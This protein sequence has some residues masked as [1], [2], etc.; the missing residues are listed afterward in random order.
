MAQRNIE[1]TLDKSLIDNGCLLC[2]EHQPHQCHRRLVAE[3]LN[4]QWDENIKIVHLS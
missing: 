4:K 2:S 1:R 3:Y